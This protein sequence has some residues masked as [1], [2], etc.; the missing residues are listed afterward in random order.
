MNEDIELMSK[1]IE[2]IRDQILNDS[3]I[4]PVKLHFNSTPYQ[5]HR[6][7]SYQKRLKLPKS[8]R[9]NNEGYIEDSE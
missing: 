5:S 1:E 4:T 2:Q 9:S 7:N 3:P 8:P 6:K